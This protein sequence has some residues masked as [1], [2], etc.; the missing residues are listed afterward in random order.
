MHD[1]WIY[2]IFINVSRRIFYYLAKD[3]FAIFNDHKNNLCIYFLRKILHLWNLIYDFVRS[4]KYVL[5]V[6]CFAT[7]NHQVKKWNAIEINI[8]LHIVWNI[9]IFTRKLTY[10]HIVIKTILFTCRKHSI[11][12]YCKSFMKNNHRNVILSYMLSS[13]MLIIIMKVVV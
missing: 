13:P 4:L 7:N 2:S 3:F 5:N 6:P 8:Q 12:G 10:I 11:Y 1:S 9:Y